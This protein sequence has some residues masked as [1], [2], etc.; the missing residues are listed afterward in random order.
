MNLSAMLAKR[1]AEGRPVRIG[2]IGAGKFGS[3]ILAQAQHID[4]YHIV[5]IADLDP[6]KAKASL[7]RVH[8]SAEQYA[9]TSLQDAVASGATHVTDDVGA[10]FSND[11]IEVIIEAT[12]HPIAGVRHAMAAIDAGKHVIMVNVEADVMCGPIIAERARKAGVVYSMAYGDQPAAMC[13]LVDWVHSCGFELVSAGKGMNFCPGYR[14]STP[15]TVWDYFDFSEE[16]V[17]SGDFNPKMY[18][19][20]TDGTKAA[21]EMAAVANA[22]GLDCPF[23]GLAFPPSSLDDLAEVFKP[24][25]EGGR[26]EKNGIVDI[27]ASREPDGRLV[28]NNIQYGMFVTFRAPN[29]YT[30]QCF[31]QYGLLTDASGWYGSMWRPFHLIGLETSVSVLS[32]A[33]R[34]EPTGTSNRYRGDAVATAKGDFAAGDML[35]GEGGFK[36]WAKAIPASRA[37]A[38]RALPIGLAHHVKLKR[39]IKRDQIVTLDDVEVADDLDIHALRDEQNALLDS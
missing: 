15:D 7:A 13:E 1:T 29:E 11:Q 12:G 28:P 32:A 22:T 24:A 19:S 10:L 9:A 14:Y 8:W 26:L 33:L 27:A 39:D 36:V 21:I 35:D 30:R 20:F 16:Q 25:S 34:G 18:N 17:K 4:G 23:D 2:L 31:D 3:M 37:V 6:S 38:E 5:G